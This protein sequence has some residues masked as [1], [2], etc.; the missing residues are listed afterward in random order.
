VQACEELLRSRGVVFGDQVGG[1]QER[2]DRQTDARDKFVYQKVCKGTRAKQVVSL[3]DQH[4]E[5]ELLPESDVFA[6]AVRY[7]QRHSLPLPQK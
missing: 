4:P 1:K 7:A 2:V 6:C 3:I 5:W